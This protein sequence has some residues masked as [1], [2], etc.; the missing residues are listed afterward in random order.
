VERGYKLTIM[1]HDVNPTPPRSSARIDN[2]LAVIK[3][4]ATGLNPVQSA[5]TRK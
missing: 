5:A 4:E 2:D 1:M 3:I